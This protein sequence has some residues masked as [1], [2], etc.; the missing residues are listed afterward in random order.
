MPP[1]TLDV[2]VI[3]A[4]ISGL[5]AAWHLQTHCPD[6]RFAVLEARPTL[7]GTWSLFRYPGFR[8]DSDMY[9]LGF[10]FE[11]WRERSAIARGPTI[12]QYLRETARGHGLERH[13]R[14][15][16]RVRSANWNP[17]A[18][19]WDVQAVRT[20][21]EG[22]EE[23][24]TFHCSF[25]FVCGGYYRYDR[26]F[27]PAFEDMA[28]FRGLHVH[29]QQWPEG[30]DCRGQRVVVI[31]SGATAATL[32]P[33]LA[34]QGAQVVLLQR[35]PSY[36]FIVPGLD[37]I[38][39]LLRRLLPARWAYALTRRKNV[40]LAAF[41]FRRSRS[42]PEK[43]RS[44]LLKQV[45]KALPPG[46]DLEPNFTPPYGPWEQRLCLVPDADLFQ[47][48]SKGQAEVVTDRIERFTAEGLRLASGRELQADV[49]V[50][51]TGLELQMLGGMQLSVDGVPVEPGRLVSYKGV[52]YGGVPNLAATFGYVA[53]S[54]TLKADLTSQYVCRVLNHLRDTGTRIAT[55]GLPPDGVALKPFTDFSSGYFQRAMHL[56][57]RQ[58][59][60][61]PWKLFD[62]YADD[63]RRLLEE[64]VDDD[65]LVFGAAPAAAPKAEL[66]Q[67]A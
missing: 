34:G 55:P 61:G 60:E 29:A 25:L 26:G 53:A 22:A 40:A 36:Y 28:S 15:G 2:L 5:S 9:T 59:A 4:G 32:V 16:V 47:A 48:L 50:S 43:V 46:Y 57:P 18:A 7:G 51:A 33:A 6:R 41:L 44:F 37:R 67:A 30:L 21:A 12:L 1:E 17:R 31:G 11:P 45:A 58:G 24:V 8:S 62:R 54:W 64:P 42:R 56:L 3:G 38:A 63:R 10:H 20:T 23:G 39:L 14:Y 66:A 19:H 52:M 13:I 27:Q 35:T 65:V 49:I